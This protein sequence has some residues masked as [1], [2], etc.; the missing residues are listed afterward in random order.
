MDI[1][2]ECPIFTW[3]SP[4]RTTTTPVICAWEI[5]PIGID[6]L[7]VFLR[8][9]FRYGIVTS[10]ATSKASARP[11]WSRRRIPAGIMVQAAVW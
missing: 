10:T 6:A 9:E 3:R 4:P 8:R 11:R 1:L 7:P 2:P 5:R